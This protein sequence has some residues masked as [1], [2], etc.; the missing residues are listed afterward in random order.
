MKSVMQLAFFLGLVTAAFGQYFT[1]M[2]TGSSLNSA[3]WQTLAPASDSSVVQSGGTVAINNRGWLISNAM[4]AAIDITLKFQFT[5][6][7]HD[8]F[9][10]FTRS[11]TTKS[12]SF[13]V[14][15]KA[16]SIQFQMQ[17]DTGQTANNVSI[18]RWDYFNTNPVG[19]QG[20]FPIVLGQSYT[21]R[22]VDDGNRVLLYINDTTNPFLT[23]ADTYKPGSQVIM[24]NREGAGNGS[25]ISA[26]SQVKISAFTV[27]AT[28][29]VTVHDQVQVP[30]PDTS[31]HLVN[32]STLDTGSFSMGFV[33]RGSTA[34][35]VLIRGV[36]PTL[37]TF[38][39]G[40]AA[41]QSTLTLYAGQAVIGTNTAWGGAANAAQIVTAATSTGA[42]A[43]PTGSGDTAILA[44]LNPGSYT[45][46]IAGNGTVLLEAYEV[47]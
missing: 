21:V 22:I 32:Q 23:Y 43:L 25:F 26:G 12:N 38:G 15:D 13:L 11:I 1:D 39:V 37:R 7:S 3:Y 27:N 40:S 2:F 31:S 8:V 42:F 28:S 4:P 20:T 14:P 5:G 36:G 10:I 34:R 30:V 44:T 16:I 41:T 29:V 6:S 19:A 47:P 35:S 9:N 45:A 18:G 17:S 24:F 46:Q 33:I